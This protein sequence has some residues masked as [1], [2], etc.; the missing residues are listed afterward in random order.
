MPTQ[1]KIPGKPYHGED[2]P[3]NESRGYYDR[4]EQAYPVMPKI[5]VLKAMQLIKDWYELSAGD[6]VRAVA[7]EHRN[8][9]NRVNAYI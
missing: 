8:A 5:E 7:S 1:M 3:C 2:H 6:V 4:K 9:L